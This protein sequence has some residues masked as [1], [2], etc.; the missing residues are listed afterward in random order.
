VTVATSPFS[1]VVALSIAP[2]LP[3]AGVVVTFGTLAAL[4]ED[5]GDTRSAVRTASTWKRLTDSQRDYLTAI[6][7]RLTTAEG[8]LPAP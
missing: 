2:P 7:R 5:F 4:R 1:T 3:P 6:E 8:R